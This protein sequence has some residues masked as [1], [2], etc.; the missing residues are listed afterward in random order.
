MMRS[1]LLLCATL[2]LLA[3]P[4]HAAVRFV[5][6]TIDDL[7]TQRGNSLAEIQA[8]TNRLVEQIRTQGTPVTAFVNE[9]KL[10]EGGEQELSARTALLE[11][12]L[13]IGVEL[14]NHT[15]SHAD[16]NAVGLDAYKQDLLRGETI[17]KQLLRKRG[18]TLTYFR[19]P[20]LH[21]GKDAR[22]KTAL[23]AFLSEHGYIVAPVTIDNDEWIYGAAY[24]KAA[25]KKDEAAMRR[26][27]ADYLVYMNRMFEFSEDIAQ[28]V[29]GRD[30][31]Q[32]LL[33]HANALNAEYY[34][35]LTAMMKERG[36]AFLSLSDALQDPA[37]R[38]EDRYIGPRGISWLL[39]WGQGKP[40]DESKA[41]QIPLYIRELSG[42]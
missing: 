21:T 6:I 18:K 28:Q 24:D 9:A 26:I 32:T 13:D 29:F 4:I 15:Y 10:H 14:G 23:T 31:K 35:K 30:I 34:D 3:L 20:Y 19:H 36:Y 25:E 38:S 12:W 8:I 33:I 11:Q 1:H 7:P 5:A 40:I 22:T 39:R 41:P 2:A 17:S 42:Y 27:G 37:Y 16:I